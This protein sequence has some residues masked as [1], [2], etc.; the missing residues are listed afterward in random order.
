MPITKHGALATV[1]VITIF[2]II[3]SFLFGLITSDYSWTDRLW[4]TTPVGYAWIYAAA[5]SWDI[6]ITI[7]ALLVTLWGARLTFNFTRRGGY[8]GGEDYRWPILREKIGNPVYWQIFNFLFISFY[9]QFLFICFT[10]PLY[11]ISQ[12]SESMNPALSAV[13]AL[14]MLGF[15]ILETVADQQQYNFQQSK[16][17]LLP[18]VSA[19]Q[20]DYERGFRTSGLFAISRHPNYLGELGVWWAIYFIS[21]GH[22]GSLVH[23]SAFGPLLLTLLFV[24][25][26]IFT[27]G[28][29]SEK[30]PLYSQYKQEVWPIFPKLSK[31]KGNPM[32]ETT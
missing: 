9:Q 29:T 15:L 27:E 1:S 5:G 7:P 14:V 23:W 2:T 32:R 8:T 31:P 28:I 3:V 11:I 17:G 26:T 16:Y 24:G 18:K 19:F 21:V 22:S 12:T 25:S 4:S 13:G 10:V 6:T 30:Y 20:D